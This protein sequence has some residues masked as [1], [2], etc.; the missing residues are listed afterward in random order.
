LRAH[1]ERHFRLRSATVVTKP[2]PKKPSER[3]PMGYAL[4]EFRQPSDAREALRRLARSR[5]EA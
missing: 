2:P 4:V 3:V 5:L 1:F